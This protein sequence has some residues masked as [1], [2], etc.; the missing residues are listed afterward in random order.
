M[1]IGFQGAV[2]CRQKRK[3]MATFVEVVEIETDSVVKRIE[4]GS[5]RRAEKVEDGLTRQINHDKYFTR[6][7]SE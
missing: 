5:D 2:V 6:V 4:C 7:V 3:L 1:E